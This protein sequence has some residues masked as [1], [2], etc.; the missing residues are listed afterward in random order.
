MNVDD[1]SNHQLVTIAVAQ[2]NGDSVFVDR[3]DIAIRVDS[4]AKGRFNWRKYPDRIDLVT[5]VVA[6][7]DAKKS[8]NGSLLVGD[9]NKGWM[10]SPEGVK[11]VKSLDIELFQASES[12]KQRRLSIGETIEVER[13]R[14]RRTNAYKLFTE[15]KRNEITQQDF[16]QFARVNDYFRNRARQR[17]F[18]IVE[19]AVMGDQMLTDLWNFLK[20][21]FDEEP[22]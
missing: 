8:K 16:Y 7:R 10:L 19:S 17:R 13:D 4:L 18:T 2:L 5:I 22:K 21:S 9:N 15:D 20:I 11:F 14:L 1:F 6:L 12:A 3:E